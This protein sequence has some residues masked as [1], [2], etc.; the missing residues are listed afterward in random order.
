MNYF[1]F[2]EVESILVPGHGGSAIAGVV[3]GGIVVVGGV[4][5]G[6]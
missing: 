5:I 1:R 3:V 2:E 4:V 6:T